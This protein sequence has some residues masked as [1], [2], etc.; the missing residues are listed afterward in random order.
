MKN[1]IKIIKKKDKKLTGF[2]ESKQLKEVEKTYNELENQHQE[3]RDNL[4]KINYLL[5]LIEKHQI[6]TSTSNKQQNMVEK[7]S[8]LSKLKEKFEKIH[9]INTDKLTSADIEFL[10]KEKGKLKIEKEQ[11]EKEHHHIHQLIAKANSYLTNL[12]NSECEEITKGYDIAKVGEKLLEHFG[13]KM[14]ETSY[15]FGRKKVIKYLE[16]TF[17]L[18]RIQA[19][20]LF[21]LLEKSRVLKYKVDYSNMVNVPVYE[22]FDEFTDFDYIPMFGNWLINA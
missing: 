4:K 9:L 18:N 2:F 1:F 19:N 7:E 22:N 13:R 16:E 12:R 3:I 11:L 17:S 14:E 10:E 8:W 21:E 6:E 5:D 15:D 20:K